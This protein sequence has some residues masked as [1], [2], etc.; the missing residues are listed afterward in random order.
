LPWV[1]GTEP[2]PQ[3]SRAAEISEAPE[4]EKGCKRGALWN[5]LGML[6]N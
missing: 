5:C 2:Q 3:K 6:T 1:G 4:T